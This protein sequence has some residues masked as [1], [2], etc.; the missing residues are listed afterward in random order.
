VLIAKRRASVLVDG[1][2]EV[3]CVTIWNL[4]RS[5]GSVTKV[6]TNERFVVEITPRGGEIADAI[7]LPI[8]AR[9]HGQPKLMRRELERVGV[10]AH[11]AWKNGR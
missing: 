1:K 10:L 6:I 9:R 11:V 8:I 5:G 3:R 2:V 4:P 7:A